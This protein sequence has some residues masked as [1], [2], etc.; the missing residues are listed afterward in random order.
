MII[1]LAPHW[2]IQLSLPLAGRAIIIR[3]FSE[4]GFGTCSSPGLED[5]KN[6]ESHAYLGESSHSSA[7][8][9]CHKLRQGLAAKTCLPLSPSLAFPSS[10]H[11]PSHPSNILSRATCTEYSGLAPRLRSPHIHLLLGSGYYNPVYDVPQRS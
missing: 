6:N 5:Y 10:L 1:V 7:S 3:S 2:G 4:L 8:G 9:Y 11:L